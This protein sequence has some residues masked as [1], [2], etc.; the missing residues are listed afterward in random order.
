MTLAPDFRHADRLAKARGP[1]DGDGDGWVYDGTP[2]KRPATPAEMAAGR[3]LRAGKKAAP[4]PVNGG[5]RKKA[6]AK[7]PY[8]KRVDKFDR[9]INAAK[10][11][12]EHKRVAE[13]IRQDLVLNATDRADL[14]AVQQARRDGLPDPAPKK[15]SNREARGVKAAPGVKPEAAPKPPAKKAAAAPPAKKAAAK[16]VAEKKADV[17]D[18][19]LIQPGGP[20]TGQRL[21]PASTPKVESNPVAAGPKHVPQFNAE[22]R[23]RAKQQA[24]KS[25]WIDAAKN[26]KVE[27]DLNRVHVAV[28]DAYGQGEIDKPTYQAVMAVIAERRKGFQA[29]KRLKG[30]AKKAAPARPPAKKA[31]PGRIRQAAAQTPEFDL[32]FV[33][34]SRLEGGKHKATSAHGVKTRAWK[35]LILRDVDHAKG[36]LDLNRA[37]RQVDAMLRN[38]RISEREAVEVRAAIDAKRKALFERPKAKGSLTRLKERIK[39]RLG[40]T[41]NT[42]TARVINEAEEKA[43]VFNQHAA[44]INM[45]RNATGP[46][47]DKVWEDI[48]RQINNDAALDADRKNLLLN[49]LGAKPGPDKKSTDFGDLP[50]ELGPSLPKKGATYKARVA[51]YDAVIR[52]AD[53]EPRAAKKERMLL[54]VIH[55]VQNDPKL[56]ES[57]ANK[58]MDAVQAIADGRTPK[59]VAPQLTVKP[60]NPGGAARARAKA[61]LPA[62]VD[63]NASPG[64]KAHHEAMVQAFDAASLNHAAD[65]AA[66]DAS[67]NVDELDALADHFDIQAQRLEQA[68][69][70]DRNWLNKNARRIGEANSTPEDTSPEAYAALKK[71]FE[72]GGSISDAPAAG[73]WNWVRAH[74]E[75]FAVRSNAKSGVSANLW[76]VDKSKVPPETWMFKKNCFQGDIAKENLASRLMQAAGLK[77]PSTRFAAARDGQPPGQQWM[78]Q[79]HYAEEFEGGRNIIDNKLHYKNNGDGF[80]ALLPKLKNGTDRKAAARMLVFDYLVDNANDR[81]RENIMFVEDRKGNLNIAIIDH[82]LAFG[83]Q[84]QQA[85]GVFHAG[86]RGD[87][88]GAGGAGVSK[89]AAGIAGDRATLKRHLKEQIAAFAKEDPAKILERMNDGL[90]DTALDAKMQRWVNEYKWRLNWLQDDANLDKMVAIAARHGGI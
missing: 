26:A 19:R 25:E 9:A 20:K 57:D 60:K 4:G 1:V 37:N 43:K 79:R 17:P 58:I 30:Q 68:E 48:K 36:M 22:Q 90:K 47:R 87:Q 65:A 28:D 66:N 24:K 55:A 49:D 10:T 77:M 53:L 84:N 62:K 18:G 15:G 70:K 45:F 78:A 46:G 88:M 39:P 27:G 63:T 69:R 38:D 16:K 67:L 2:K 42:R 41:P 83:D 51:G 7:T 89:L 5:G 71:H 50:D 86:Y 29:Q 59:A 11:P 80:L 44:H 33:T 34:D 76:V 61:K 6:P 3:A 52:A 81:H 74:P 13:L 31:A 12:A 54:D 82:G 8:D 85:F 72:G 40:R 23:A 21:K 73:L 32:G 14:A 56:N 35:R 75:Q 64:F